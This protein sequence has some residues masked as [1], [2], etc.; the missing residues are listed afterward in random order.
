M[1]DIFSL[2]KIFNRVSLITRFQLT[3]SLGKAGN[4]FLCQTASYGAK[5]FDLLSHI[6]SNMKKKLLKLK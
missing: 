4:R 3:L 6:G 1:I 2:C 5:H